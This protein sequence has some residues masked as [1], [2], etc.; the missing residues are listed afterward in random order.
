VNIK[1]SAVELVGNTPLVQLN[2]IMKEE[3][4]HGKLI[5][6]L[7]FYNP[8]GSIKC[9]IAVHMLQEAIRRGQIQPG[10]MIVEPTSGNTGI[11]LAMAAS[12]LGYPVT[13]V[14]SEAMSIERRLL[15]K[16]YGA[17]LVLTEAT[18]G[19]KGAIAKALEL[20]QE[21][22]EW[23]MPYQF[24][25][26]D[27]PRAHY[28]FT[29]PE[30]WEATDGSV[31]VFVAGVGTGGTI[32]GVGK[33]LREKK[34]NIHI[35][36]VEPAASAVLSGNQPGPHQIQGIGAGFIPATLDTTIYDEIIP[37]TNEQAIQTARMLGK[38][39]GILAGIS[40][41]AALAAAI[42]VAKRPESAGKTIVFILPDNGERYLST[43]LY[44]N[45]R[46]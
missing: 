33:Y 21:N 10:T 29:G 14:M 15:M 11:G 34:K 31:D 45:D 8:A 40:G 38:W 32:S 16:G 25:N 26:K 41:G 7:E 18:K 44:Q 24:E 23:F 6:K 35:V 20:K 1:Q 28:R 2:R 17:N 19:M 12:A 4:L 27:N 9:R 46:T 30:L 22:P 37:I 42:Q 36:A 13:L 3:Q 43:V 5:A 39:E